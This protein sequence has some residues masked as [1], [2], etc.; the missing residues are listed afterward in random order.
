M[1]DDPRKWVQVASDLRARIDAGDLKPQDR[2]GTRY[3]MQARGLSKNTV[4]K[5]LRALEAEGRLK[6]FPGHGYVV[7][8]DGRPERDNA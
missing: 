4:R 5:A 3:E 1:T 6:R 8:G 2:V 7:W